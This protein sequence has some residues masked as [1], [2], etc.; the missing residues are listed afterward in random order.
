MCVHL[1]KCLCVMCAS[2]L[3]LQQ[4]VLKL[5]H[6]SV[7]P[8]VGCGFFQNILNLTLFHQ[9]TLKR[10]LIS[11][12]LSQASHTFP[13]CGRSLACISLKGRWRSKTSKYRKCNCYILQKKR[14][15]LITVFLS[16]VPEESSSAV[17]GLIDNDIL[18]VDNFVGQYSLFIWYYYC[19]FNHSVNTKYFASWDQMILCV[20]LTKFIS[21][22]LKITKGWNTCYTNNT[23]NKIKR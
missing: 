14:I 22:S 12:R 18:P 15:C 3:T 5:L 11:H 20:F 13:T 17:Q 16:P 19:I 6:T 4:Q 9:K 21:K 1:C 10:H 23:N 7:F 2:C 8:P